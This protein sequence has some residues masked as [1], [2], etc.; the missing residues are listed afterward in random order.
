MVT[1][2]LAK[3]RAGGRHRRYLGLQLGVVLMVWRLPGVCISKS[4]DSDDHVKL[5]TKLISFRLYNLNT[6]RLG[7]SRS[8]IVP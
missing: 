3:S 5:D 8:V 6:Q 2:K 1:R 4:D 7:P